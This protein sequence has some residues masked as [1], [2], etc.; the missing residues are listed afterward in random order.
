[1][2]VVLLCLGGSNLKKAAALSTIEAKFVVVSKAL[3]EMIWLQS[4]LEE[5]GKKNK[6]GTLYSDSQ[7]AIFLTKNPIPYQESNI[8]FHQT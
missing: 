8:S 7:S 6:K 2:W 5:F 3:K 1:M 4:F